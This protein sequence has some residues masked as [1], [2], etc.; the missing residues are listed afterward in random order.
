MEDL[1]GNESVEVMTK[2][3]MT[4][5][6]PGVPNTAMMAGVPENVDELINSL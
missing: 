4:A 2:H 1:Q 5:G 6:V 3:S